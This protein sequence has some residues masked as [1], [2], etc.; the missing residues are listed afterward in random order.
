MEYCCLDSSVR[1]YN[2]MPHR[3]GIFMIENTAET[4]DTLT[5][6]HLSVIEIAIKEF[7][8]LK[9]GQKALIQPYTQRDKEQLNK[10]VFM[11]SSLMYY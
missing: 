8:D 10:Q 4:K 7:S 5:F 3:G 2:T 1:A 9:V 6:P 11:K